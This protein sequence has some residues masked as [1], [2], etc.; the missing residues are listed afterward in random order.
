MC[1]LVTRVRGAVSRTG[2]VCWTKLEVEGDLLPVHRA[3]I[4][5]SVASV[6][7]SLTRPGQATC[8]G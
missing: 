3:Y 1:R 8:I 7:F 6:L 4:S 5:N 2:L